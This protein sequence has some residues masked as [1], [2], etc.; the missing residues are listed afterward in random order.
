[1]IAAI[2]WIRERPQR[3]N[4]LGRGLRRG[5]HGRS[6]HHGFGGGPWSL[7]GRP[8]EKT[9]KKSNKKIT[10]VDQRSDGPSR[11]GKTVM[12]RGGGGGG[13]G[14]GGGTSRL[15]S[16]KDVSKKKTQTGGEE[17]GKEEKVKE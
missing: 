11:P 16:Y 7:D 2:K 17:V 12:M 8:K 13:G 3:E 10:K 4:Y 5:R 1:L 9:M 6:F 15:E 14:I